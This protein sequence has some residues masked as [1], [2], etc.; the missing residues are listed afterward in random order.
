MIG[1]V[2]GLSE[3]KVIFVNINEPV[4]LNT[5]IGKKVLYVDNSNREWHGLVKGI[6]NELLVVEMENMPT[7]M[8]QGQIVEIIT[9]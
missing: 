4:D 8:G 3:E 7:S 6:E 5:L 2:A 1:I 9:E